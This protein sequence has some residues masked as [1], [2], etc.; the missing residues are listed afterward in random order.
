MLL[1]VAHQIGGSFGHLFGAKERGVRGRLASTAPGLRLKNYL[2]AFKSRLN[3]ELLHQFP[4]LGDVISSG[5]TDPSDW[6]NAGENWE[7]P[8]DGRR[9]DGRDV[10]PPRGHEP[11]VRQRQ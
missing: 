2:N 1:T 11:V 7:T 9:N 10:A 6:T 8:R 3:P 4:G 5:H